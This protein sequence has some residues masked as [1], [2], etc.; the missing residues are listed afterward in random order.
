MPAATSRSPPEEMTPVQVPDSVAD[1]LR[2]F[3]DTKKPLETRRR[4]IAELAKRGDARA[5]DVLMALG[6]ER[7]YL[8]WAAVEALGAFSRSPE[9]AAVQAYLKE[10]LR[11]ADAQTVCAA[12]RG[13]AALMGSDGVEELAAMLP[14]NRTRADGHQ[15]MV[16]AAI[17]QALGETASPRATP[18]LAAE[19]ERCGDKNWSLEYG[20]RVLSAMRTVPS[21]EARKAASAYAASLEA[22]Q[23]A[24]PPAK[25]YYEAKIQEARKAAQP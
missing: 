21:E 14:V 10:K 12:V 13:Y 5:L 2:F 11:A 23:P 16:C 3:R 19:L 18:I 22:R 7:A 15:E 1:A 4:A 6:G 8:S 25:Q 9:K 17:V 24:N 20:S